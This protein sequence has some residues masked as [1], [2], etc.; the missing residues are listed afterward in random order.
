LDS[1]KLKE[2]DELR[3]RYDFGDDWRFVLRVD[4]SSKSNF[5]VLIITY[6]DIVEGAEFD[7]FKVLKKQGKAPKQ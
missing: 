3:M 2:G 6:Q 1:L 7:S 5:H 4:V